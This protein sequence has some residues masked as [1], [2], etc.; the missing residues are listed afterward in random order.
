MQE[1]GGAA[2]EAPSRSQRGRQVCRCTRAYGIAAHQLMHRWQRA[3]QADPS[4]GPA[5]RPA[6]RGAKANVFLEPAR[7][8]IDRCAMHLWHGHRVARDPA[9]ALPSACPQCAGRPAPAPARGCPPESRVTRPTSAA[10]RAGFARGGAGEHSHRNSTGRLR[11]LCDGPAAHPDGQQCL[12]WGALS[13]LRAVRAMREPTRSARAA[14][15]DPG[16]GD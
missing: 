2:G 10:G 7:G 11:M 12:G 14:C 13:C 9:R 5:S 16:A 8:S 1:D 3:V 6:G 15:A 4:P